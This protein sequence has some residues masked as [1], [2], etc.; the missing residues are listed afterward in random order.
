MV[1][2]AHFRHI[3]RGKMNTLFEEEIVSV[4]HWTDRLFSFRTTR[5]PSFRFHSGQFT[6]IGLPEDGRPLLRAYS[7]VSPTMPTSSN[8]SLLKFQTDH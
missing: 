4:H 3:A 7:I 5:D 8:F 6:M 1:S 2:I